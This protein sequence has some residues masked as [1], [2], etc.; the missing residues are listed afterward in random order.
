[1]NKAIFYALLLLLIAC[2][3]TAAAEDLQAHLFDDLDGDGISDS[4]EAVD[5]SQGNDATPP[6]DPDPSSDPGTNP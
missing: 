1:M 6:A 3:R 2:A 4:Q 5:A